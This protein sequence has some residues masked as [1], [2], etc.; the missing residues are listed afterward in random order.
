MDL[1]SP[2]PIAFHPSL[3]E[4]GREDPSSPPHHKK[5]LPLVLVWEQEEAQHGRVGDLVVEGLAVEMQ[6]GGVD[7]DVVS[8]T[9]R[10][11][12][13]FP[14]DADGIS[15]GLDHVRLGEDVLSKGLQ[16]KGVTAR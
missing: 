7:A 2:K 9:R 3:G 10:Q 8:P 13:Q 16:G 11:T 4:G 1:K 5:H 12:L 15:S 6:E 14:E